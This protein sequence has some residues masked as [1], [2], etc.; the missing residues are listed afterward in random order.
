MEKIHSDTM[1]T[2][3]R[4]L[5]EASEESWNTCEESKLGELKTHKEEAE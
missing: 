3:Q 2:R 1:A 5:D 4:N